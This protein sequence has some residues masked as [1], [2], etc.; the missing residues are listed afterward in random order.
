MSAKR[1]DLGRIIFLGVR[2]SM[3]KALRAPWLECNLVGLRRFGCGVNYPNG[4]GQKPSFTSY[5][6]DSLEKVG[7]LRA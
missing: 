2:F 5:D 7:R 4:T 1:E 6:M 3:S